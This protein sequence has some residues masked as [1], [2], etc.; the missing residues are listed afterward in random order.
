MMTIAEYDEITN[1][2]I[3]HTPSEFAMKWWIGAAG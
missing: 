2:F 3:M 1:E